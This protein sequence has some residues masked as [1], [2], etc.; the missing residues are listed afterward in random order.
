MEAVF[1]VIQNGEQ[2]NCGE[3][4]FAAYRSQIMCSAPSQYGLLLWPLPYEVPRVPGLPQRPY[5]SSARSIP[6]QMNEAWS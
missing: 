2:G 3:L 1:G 6:R 4:Q 5:Y